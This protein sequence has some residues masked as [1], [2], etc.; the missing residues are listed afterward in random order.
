MVGCNGGGEVGGGGAGKAWYSVSNG[1]ESLARGD[2]GWG[3]LT[4][5]KDCNGSVTIVSGKGGCEGGGQE[6]G[7]KSGVR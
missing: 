4:G 3:G 6:G 1:R 5:T 7:G 2:K